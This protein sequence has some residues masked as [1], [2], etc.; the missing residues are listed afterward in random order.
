MF[1]L[2][3]LRPVSTKEQT[4]GESPA[5]RILLIAVYYSIRFSVWLLNRTL[6]THR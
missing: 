5:G 4:E 1:I 3:A 2:T 6:S